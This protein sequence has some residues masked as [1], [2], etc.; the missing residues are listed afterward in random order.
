MREI[1][2]NYQK[3]RT[4]FLIRVINIFRDFYE[5]DEFF[6]RLQKNNIN[7]NIINAI[8]TQNDKASIP[9]YV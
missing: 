4:S 6:V 7:K 5:K 2:K 1:Q 8:M 9:Y 3:N